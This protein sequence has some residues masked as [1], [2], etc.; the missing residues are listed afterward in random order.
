MIL[1][2]RKAINQSVNI[3]GKVVKFVG[4]KAEVDDDFGAEILKMGIPDIY[5]FGKQPEIFSAREV[6]MKSEFSERE[7]WYRKEIEKYKNIV[8]TYKQKL[9]AVQADVTAWKNEFEKEHNLRM[10]LLEATQNLS[11]TDA[12]DD[13][14]TGSKEAENAESTTSKENAVNESEIE[15]LRTELSAMKKDDLIKFGEDSGLDMSSV[16]NLTKKEIVDFILSEK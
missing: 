1:Y 10:S 4:C 13:S 7:D 8:Q 11:S 5:E 9:E 6:K 3:N 14:S 2:N 12:S 15:A 16:S